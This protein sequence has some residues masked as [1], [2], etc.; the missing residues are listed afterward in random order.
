[1]SDSESEPEQIQIISCNTCKK[2]Y[3]T[4]LLTTKNHI[5]SL[6]NNNINI[7]FKYMFYVNFCL[8]N[9]I[10]IELYISE[11][12]TILQLVYILTPLIYHEF[13]FLN[14]YNI[15]IL[16]NPALL[17]FRQN[18]NNLEEWD[19]PNYNIPIIVDISNHRNLND[20]NYLPE[21]KNFFKTLTN[22]F[23]NNYIPYSIGKIIELCGHNYTI[24]SFL[25]NDD[26]TDDDTIES[27]HK[28]SIKIIKVLMNAQ[29]NNKSLYKEFYLNFINH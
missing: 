12:Q 25:T 3:V 5:C 14:K 7:N 20:V 27:K 28:L 1:M 23:P 19:L 29:K 13:N 22:N 6:C 21:L 9:N 4:E 11:E 2:I 10:N 8:I 15:D 26:I 16:Q 24:S 17:S 18:E